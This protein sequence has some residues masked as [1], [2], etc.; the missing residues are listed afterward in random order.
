MPPYTEDIQ[1]VTGRPVFDITS[2]VRLVH[3]G[4][5]AALGPLPA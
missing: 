5:A 2:L 1:R 3:D 4:L